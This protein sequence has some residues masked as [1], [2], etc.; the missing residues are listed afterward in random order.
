[1]EVTFSVACDVGLADISTK[2][3][4]VII[5]VWV[6]NFLDTTLQ[7]S[8]GYFPVLFFDKFQSTSTL[9]DL[10][11]HKSVLIRLEN[12][13]RVKQRSC[14]ITLCSFFI[15]LLDFYDHTFQ[16]LSCWWP[17]INQGL[18]TQALIIE[19]M[20]KSVGIP[21]SVNESIKIQVNKR[22]LSS[23]KV[24]KKLLK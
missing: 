9:K 23:K 6:V 22:D 16:L 11:G 7:I 4:F 1:M 10:C 8:R 17:V 15:V 14:L 5:F 19:Q 12:P 3:L 21:R 24:I 13:Q 2:L 20:Q 18:R